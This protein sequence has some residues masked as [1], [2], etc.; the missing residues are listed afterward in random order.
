MKELKGVID[1]IPYEGPLS[2][3]GGLLNCVGT[4][5]GGPDN[6]HHGRGFD[7][8]STIVRKRRPNDRPLYILIDSDINRNYLDKTGY[9]Y[10]G[11]ISIEG[12]VKRSWDQVYKATIAEALPWDVDL[13]LISGGMKG[14]TV[15]SNLTFP[16]I[17]GAYSQANYSISLLGGNATGV[18][19]GK[20]KA[21]ISAECYRYYPQAARKRAIPEAFYDRIHTKDTAAQN[22]VPSKNIEDSLE[23]QNIQNIQNIRGTENVQDTESIRNVPNIQNVQSTRYV[24]NTQNIQ[25]VPSSKESVPQRQQ[26]QYTGVNV[27]QELYKLAGFGN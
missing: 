3:V 16:G 4:I 6:F 25:N 18:T 27:S 20:G 2:M 10:V 11:K 1:S 19:E 15:G 12:T 23:I 9:I 24:P 21:M 22:V 13:L 26:Q 14:V 8:A 5:M 7:I 17:A